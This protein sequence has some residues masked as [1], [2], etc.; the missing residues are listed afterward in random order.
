MALIK[1]KECGNMVSDRAKTCP[2]C[3]CPVGNQ[4]NDDPQGQSLAKK[5]NHGSNNNKST[6]GGL[7]WLFLII[8]IIALVIIL[9]SGKGCSNS[10]TN[11]M[12]SDSCDTTAVDTAAVVEDFDT[13]AQNTPID[14]ITT[15]D[16]ET[17]IE[18]ENF[19]CHSEDIYP[20]EEFSNDK[21]TVI[22]GKS[23]QINNAWLE[24]D[25]DNGIRI[26]VD[27][28]TSNLL[29]CKVVVVCFFWFKDGRKITST[30]GNYEAADRQVATHVN[31][32]PKY[33]ESAWNDLQLWIPY[34]QIKSV[35]DRKDLKCRVE[36]FY[37]NHCLA[38]GNYMNF[39]CWLD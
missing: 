23:A 19:N 4:A 1:C 38:T 16:N 20:S 10:S 18:S 27:M 11:E 24:H 5:E 6:S 32:N 21:G 31:I 25:A 13:V 15:T 14:D 29:N 35:R 36:V 2:K 34:S 37:N 22:D 28:T 8:G 3:G 39:A 30:D 7:L 12:W 9:L 17:S 26:H 33:Q